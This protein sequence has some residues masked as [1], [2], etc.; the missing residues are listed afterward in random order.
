MPAAR[1]YGEAANNR[2]IAARSGVKAFVKAFLDPAVSR[3]CLVPL[4]SPPSRTI[5]ATASTRL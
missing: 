2:I 4:I 1:I 3:L 5:P